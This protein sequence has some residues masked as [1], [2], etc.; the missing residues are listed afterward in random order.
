MLYVNSDKYP[1]LNGSIFSG[2]L[3][4]QYLERLI[5]EGKQAVKRERWF[6]NIGRVREITQGPDGYI[7]IAVEGK[8]IFKIVPKTPES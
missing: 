1:E 3:K 4:F 6:E 8:G 5:F 2:S 7:Y